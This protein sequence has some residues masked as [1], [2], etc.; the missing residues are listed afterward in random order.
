M[1]CHPCHMVA[2]YRQSGAWVALTAALLVPRAAFRSLRGACPASLVLRFSL[3]DAWCVGR[4]WVPGR[5]ARNQSC[6][7]CATND[8]AFLAQT[9]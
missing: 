7:P 5:A 3:L 6:A 2:E 8:V 1:A 9:M 4:A